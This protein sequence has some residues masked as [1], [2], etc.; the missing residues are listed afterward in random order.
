MSV[1][2]IANNRL[3]TIL[4]IFVLINIIGDIGNVIAWWAVPSMPGLSLYNSYIGTAINNNQTALIIGSIILLVVAAVYSVSLFGLRK[5]MLWAPLLV[6][7][8]SIVNRAIAIGLYLLSFAFL[9]LAETLGA[10]G[11]LICLTL[12]SFI[13]Y[14]NYFDISLAVFVEALLLSKYWMVLPHSLHSTICHRR[15]HT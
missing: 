6:I 3:N 8:I 7:V 5:K 13:D 12:S 15:S 9:F 11:H 14:G 1:Q 10:R 4:E 2:P